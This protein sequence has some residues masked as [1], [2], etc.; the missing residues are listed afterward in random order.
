MPICSFET[1]TYQWL[2]FDA[3]DPDLPAWLMANVPELPRA[4]LTQTETRPRCDTYDDGLILNLR[5]VNMNDGQKAFDM[6]SLRLWVTQGLIVTVRFRK[7]FA[8]DDMRKDFEAGK[9]PKDIGAFLIRLTSGLTDRIETTVLSGI[10]QA[11]YVEQSVF[12]HGA[13][14][15]SDIGPA[16]REAISLRRYLTPQKDALYKL[17]SADVPFLDDTAKLHLRETTNRTTVAVES[18]NSVHDRLIAA[19]DHLDTAQANRFGRNGYVLSIVAA[20]FL[21]LGFLTG[22][23]GMNVAGLPGT[24][25]PMAFATL[26]IA[27]LL[28]AIV[29]LI[30]F[31][32]K[33]WL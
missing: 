19:Q 5:G 28:V 16:R 1:G 18:L 4:T 27:M 11:D 2:H 26:C 9:H 8:V 21:P 7:I 15:A 24:E 23:F 31:K 17:S 14:A 20:I 10:E 12:E 33:D 32:M 29:L 13:S 3:A 25:W 30:V 22:V 6:V